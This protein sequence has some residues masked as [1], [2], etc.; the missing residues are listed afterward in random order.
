MDVS[1]VPAL[2]RRLG[3]A[4]DW[5]GLPGG[6]ARDVPCSVPSLHGVAPDAA[7][8]VPRLDYCASS[9]ST[10]TA[11]FAEQ[12]IARIAVLMVGGPVL[13]TRGSLHD[14]RVMPANDRS[15]RK[16]QGLAVV[17]VAAGWLS[18]LAFMFHAWKDRVFAGGLIIAGVT[19]GLLFERWRQRG[20]RLAKIPFFVAAAAFAA[21]IIVASIAPREYALSGVIA[22]AGAVAAWGLR[23]AA[24]DDRIRGNPTAGNGQPPR[25][26]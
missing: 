25:E 18:M 5:V 26:P 24:R 20:D 4:G 16:L 12:R 13:A 1:S 8:Q 6:H 3:A 14:D 15:F 2:D 17:V 7:C 23:A 22:A 11:R 19:A 9:R 21:A 10:R